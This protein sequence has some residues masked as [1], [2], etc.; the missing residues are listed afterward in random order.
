[1]EYASTLIIPKMADGTGLDCVYFNGR[2]RYDFS[3]L[4]AK[5]K[6]KM[7]RRRSRTYAVEDPLLS[8]A[9]DAGL[10]DDIDIAIGEDTIQEPTQLEPQRSSDPPPSTQECHSSSILDEYVVLLCRYE[11]VTIIDYERFCLPEFSQHKLQ[12]E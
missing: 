7:R 3:G 9:D 12:V 10:D 1:M 5:D 11:A 2:K 6:S 4:R 8:D